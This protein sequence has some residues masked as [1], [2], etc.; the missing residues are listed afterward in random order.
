MFLHNIITK[1]LLAVAALSLLT[2][3]SCDEL[4]QDERLEYVKPAQVSRAVLI[5][6][7]TGQKC[8]NCPLATDEIHALQEQ[9][10]DSVVIAVGIHS[11]PLGFK[12]NKRSVGLATTLGDTYYNY[13]GPDHQPIGLVNR[14]GGLNDYPAWAALVRQALTETA[15]LDIHLSTD[16]TA[17]SRQLNVTAAAYGTNGTTTGKL[18]VWLVE[19]S[20]TAMQ[21]IPD[22]STDVEY[23]HNHVLRATM[24]GDWGEDITVNEGSTT[25]KTYTLA[26]DE[27]WIP[28]HVS[29]IAFVYNDG[30]VQQV[31]KKPIINNQPTQ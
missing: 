19:D 16:Y 31:V 5:E 17:D 15:P 8:V 21:M 11:G 10:G 30:G 18:Q 3:A 27:K 12:G 4:D 25:D 20:I 13:W 2:L 28:A 26:L 6:D 9:Y 23:V 14:V 1:P 29:V 7:F 24:N 22:G